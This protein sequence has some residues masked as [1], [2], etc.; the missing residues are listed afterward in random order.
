MRAASEAAAAAAR[1]ARSSG[2]SYTTSSSSSSLSRHALSQRRHPAAPCPV[3][4]ERRAAR[5]T[6]LGECRGGA[7]GGGRRP[8]G[9]RERGLRRLSDWDLLG[10][11]ARPHPLGLDSMLNA[12]VVALCG[13]GPREVAVLMRTREEALDYRALDELRAARTVGV[14]DTGA[15]EGVRRGRALARKGAR[16]RVRLAGRVRTQAGV[17]LGR[18]ALA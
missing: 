11:V 6:G 4:R 17:V 9:R 13:E 18:G 15:D 3:L 10:D 12:A 7:D 16:E 5:P 14:D 2:L 8:R 1:H